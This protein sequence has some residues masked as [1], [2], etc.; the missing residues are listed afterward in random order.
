MPIFY[1]MAYKTQQ[2][3]PIL[4]YSPPQA[5]FHEVKFIFWE[6]KWENEGSS[7]PQQFELQVCLSP[8]QERASKIL[9]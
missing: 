5:N 3:E 4:D 2:A 6:C 9:K 8:S 1:Q 7:S